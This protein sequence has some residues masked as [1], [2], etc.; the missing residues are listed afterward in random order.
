VPNPTP[1]LIPSETTSATTIGGA[2]RRR[3]VPR[4]PH[5]VP[6]RLVVLDA[7]GGERSATCGETVNISSTG[8]AIQLGRPIPHGTEVEVLIPHLDDEP[9]HVHGTVI[10]TR[11]VVTGTFEIGIRRE[12]ECDPLWP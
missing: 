7:P 4:S 3:A 6:C 2:P 9:I 8:V 1:Y 12:L 10:H 11:R 5:R